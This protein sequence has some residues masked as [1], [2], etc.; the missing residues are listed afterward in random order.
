MG[1]TSVIFLFF[2]MPVFFLIYYWVPNNKKNIFILLVSFLILFWIT[3][4][5]S[6]VMLI[7]ACVNFS[8]CFV[9]YKL[10]FLKDKRKY[11]FLMLIFMNLVAF[12]IL[13][14]FK[15]DRLVYL[16]EEL[17]PKIMISLFVCSNISYILD[18]YL[19]KCRLQRNFIDFL[20]YVFFFPKLFAG[21]LVQ[22]SSIESQLKNR[23]V[24]FQNVSEGMQLFVIGLAQKCVLADSVNEAQKFVLY[25]TVNNISV[26]TAW[27]GAIVEFFYLYFY[28][29]GYSN[30]ARGLG[31]MIGFELPANFR[32][33]LPSNSVTN[34]FERWNISLL[35]CVRTYSKPFI[36]TSKLPIKIVLL[37]L[38]GLIYA[39]FFGAGF[40]KC[41]AAVYFVVILALERL[42]IFDIL[43]KLPQLVR[44][45][46]TFL[47]VLIGTVLFWQNSIG[48]SLTYVG[49]MFGENRA[50]LDKSFIFF[51]KSFAFIL[52][53]CWLFSTNIVRNRVVGFKKKHKVT[54]YWMR[55]IFNLVLFVISIAFCITRLT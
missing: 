25:Q 14:F 22:Y 31:K 28:L 19:K 2:V 7:I 29:Y 24:I 38:G 41:L 6:F 42:F 51:A 36:K 40:S 15:L 3:P 45:I 12:G 18:V 9:M 47:L 20:T 50:F 53:L 33:I 16:Q 43:V 21:P 17:L 49:A 23:K 5:L 32:A 27:L 54:Y 48:E 26:S 35:S 52:L 44:R 4:I 46:Y 8:L 34:F 39:L 37:F 10:Y 30:M 11:I 55:Y 13:L 1:L